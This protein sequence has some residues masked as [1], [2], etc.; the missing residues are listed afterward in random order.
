MSN[1][2]SFI[3]EVTEEV[4]RDR[5]F[6]L[7]RRYG[8][9][10]VLGVVA[11]VGAAAFTEYRKATNRAQAEALG[12]AM[13]SA[14]SDANAENRA[15]GLQALQ[16]HSAE[17][18]AALALLTASEAVLAG[19]V[20]TAAKQ[21]DELAADQTVPQI[22]R[23]I[24]R[25]KSITAQAATLPAEDLKTRLEQLNVPGAPLRLLAQEQ[26]ALVD[27]AAGDTAQAITRLQSIV[28]DAEVRAAVQ[29]RALQL[30]VA[31][32]GTPEIENMPQPIN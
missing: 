17:S 18:R 22:Y 31:L 23:D 3:E 26:L 10:A 2:D 24:A 12:D 29:Q 19:D 32:G 9:I 13:L 16:G 15:L 21:L 5:L 27:I 20:E 1:T 4:R 8:W 28:M 14:L 30:I 6:A 25:F 7:L 11:I